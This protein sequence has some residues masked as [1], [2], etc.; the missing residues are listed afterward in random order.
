MALIA[1]FE[2]DS[3]LADRAL[4]AVPEMT[5]H[6]EASYMTADRRLHWA[7]WASGAAY[8]RFERALD[9]DPTVDAVR[10]LTNLKDRR[11]Y[12][13]VV[14]ASPGDLVYSCMTELGI[15]LLDA[16]HS[17]EGTR[18]RLRCPDRPAFRTFREKWTERHGGQCRTLR[19]YREDSPRIDVDLL[20][21]KQHD[22]LRHALEEGYFDVPRRTTLVELGDTLGI[23]DAAASQRIRRGVKEL[24]DAAVGPRGDERSA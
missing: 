13:I 11:L 3:S 5:L 16:D 19:L 15:Q 4:A 22:M 1:E 14:D 7:T 23:S 2:A 10:M 8:D 24:V 20:T 21:S 17:R 12:E 18:A 9:G 6:Y